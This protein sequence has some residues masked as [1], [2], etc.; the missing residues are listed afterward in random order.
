MDLTLI[1]SKLFNFGLAFVPALFGII[2]HEVAHGWSAYKLGDPTAK[3]LG[4]LTLNPIKHI[5]PLG[6]GVFVFTALFSPFIFGWA[7]PIPVQSRFFKNQ[8][9]GMMIVSFAGP[10]TNFLVALLFAVLLKLC[11]NMAT[12]G[13]ISANTLD[14][15]QQIAMH[16]VIINCVLAWF[17]LLPIPPLDGSHILAGLM[18]PAMAAH[19]ESIGRYGMM[20]LMLLIAAGAFRRIIGPLVGFSSEALFSLVGLM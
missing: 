14:I 18:P 13:I 15:L 8:R 20:I 9:T 5:D 1:S 17:N 2:C 11:F 7:K 4:R 16:G 3:Y 19:Y 10:L 6:F 12:A